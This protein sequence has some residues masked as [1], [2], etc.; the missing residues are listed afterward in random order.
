MNMPVGGFPGFNMGGMSG[1]QDL[2]SFLSLLFQNLAQDPSQGGQSHQHGGAQNAGWGGHHHHH[3]GGS[4]HSDEPGS[5]DSSDSS[6]ESC[7][8]GGGD[9]HTVDGT[10]SWDGDPHGHVKVSVDGQPQKDLNFDTTGTGLA[11]M[12]D[13][14][15]LDVDSQ[16]EGQPNKTYDVG[17]RITATGNDGEKI[18]IKVDAK[19]DKVTVDGQDLNGTYNQHGITVTKDGNKTTVTMADGTKVTSTDKGDHLDTEIEFHNMQTGELGG[20]FGTAARTGQKDGDITHF[21]AKDSHSGHGTHHTADSQPYRD[22]Q[23]A[24]D[25][26]NGMA[27]NYSGNNF[28]YTLFSTLAQFFGNSA[29]QGA[30]FGQHMWG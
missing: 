15:K 6:D 25:I 14:D 22:S 29:F 5:S 1:P 16:L 2:F 19:S 27:N 26:C 10:I 28:L 8:C 12:F 3:C 11:R 24:S 23:W 4:D 21:P 13:S 17:D 9:K 20:I 18:V 30:G 7:G